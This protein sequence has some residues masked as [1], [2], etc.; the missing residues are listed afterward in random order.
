MQIDNSSL[1]FE[2]IVEFIKL[3][4][5][6]KIQK[7]N[8]IGYNARVYLLDIELALSYK[9]T[10]FVNLLFKIYSITIFIS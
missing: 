2:L 10:V 1:F 5:Q 8:C 3:H 9:I 4:A 6:S 7:L